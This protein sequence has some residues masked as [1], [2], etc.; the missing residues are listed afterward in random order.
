M[1]RFIGKHR[2]PEPIFKTLERW[3]ALC[4]EQ[5]GSF[6]FGANRPLWSEQN[7]AELDRCYAGNLITDKGLNYI[8]KLRRQL[9][10]ASD[11]V[12]LLTAELEWLIRMPPA[13]WSVK[14]KWEMSE[15]IF[16]WA[17]EPVTKQIESYM[18]YSYQSPGLANMGPGYAAARHWAEI[19]YAIRLLLAFKQS[20]EREV[21]LND[22]VAFGKFCDEQAYSVGQKFH[23][24]KG[25]SKNDPK[26]QFRH[27]IIYMLFPNVRERLFTI[28]TRNNILTGFDSFVPKSASETER[29]IALYELRKKLE[30]QHGNFDWFE[31]EEVCKEWNPSFWRRR[32]AGR[33]KGAAPQYGSPPWER[34]GD[35]NSS[36][37]LPK[38]ADDSQAERS[39]LSANGASGVENGRTR[40]PVPTNFLTLVEYERDLSGPC[41]TYAMRFG[42]R[43]VWK[44]GLTKDLDRRLKDAN[45]F[46]PYEVL[47]E[48]W[49]IVYEQKHASGKKAHAMEQAILRDA[50]AKYKVHGERVQCTEREVKQLWT[51]AWHK[52]R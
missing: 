47:K 50:E 27:V 36:A 7:F 51:A 28:G 43:D 23:H 5:D 26:F 37:D 46:V 35:N 12:K 8:E 16:G 17:Q 6:F 52:N 25:I 9:A 38:R 2:N 41:F 44:I 45:S 29:D 30:P 19:L 22:P 4:L 40:G 42:E 34:N 10:P 1:S 3:R 33:D 39:S 18:G 14:Q 20:N 48:K 32:R 31:T 21:L 49:D 15:R 11:D 13:R 24:M